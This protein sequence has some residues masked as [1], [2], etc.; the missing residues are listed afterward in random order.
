[1]VKR[2]TD[3]SETY[4]EV[5]FTLPVTV[6]DALGTPLSGPVKMGHDVAK[7][8]VCIGGSGAGRDQPFPCFMKSNWSDLIIVKVVQQRHI[9]N[10]V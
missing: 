4:K 7:G 8:D 6:L 5:I 1:M 9:P 2:G 10:L 3:Y